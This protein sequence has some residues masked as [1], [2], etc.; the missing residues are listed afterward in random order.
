MMEVEEGGSAGKEEGKAEERCW[1]KER[2]VHRGI[3]VVVRES[4]EKGKE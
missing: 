3:N 4:K 1:I 2:G